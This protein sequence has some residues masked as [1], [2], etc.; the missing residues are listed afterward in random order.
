[1]AKIDLN[2]VTFAIHAYFRRICMESAEH[3][4]AYISPTICTNRL[5]FGNG[6]FI[7]LFFLNMTSNP[8]ITLRIWTFVTSLFSSIFTIW[9]SVA[10]RHLGFSKRFNQ[11]SASVSTK[12][13]RL[14]SLRFKA[15]NFKGSQLLD[16][17]L[18]TNFSLFNFV[19]S[20]VFSFFNAWD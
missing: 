2:I 7:I 1:M 19:L 17:I 5:I 20:W 8:R 12:F 9:K 4:G 11:V 3:N 6:A 16:N 15:R 10:E 14:E 13:H 18:W